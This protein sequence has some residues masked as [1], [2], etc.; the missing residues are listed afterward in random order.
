MDAAYQKVQDQASQWETAAGAS[1]GSATDKVTSI[2]PAANV[3]SL[4]D[5]IAD[6]LMDGLP[7]KAHALY[8]PSHHHFQSGGKLLRGILALASGLSHGVPQKT[9]LHWALAIEYMHNA[10]LVHDDLCDDDISRRN[11]PSIWVAFN[12]PMAICLGDWMIG[13][14]FAHAAAAQEYA[15]DSHVSG[16]LATTLSTL[17]TGQAKEFLPNQQLDIAAY[18]D[19]VAGKTTPLFVAAMEGI[20]RLAGQNDTSQI[21]A[22]QALFADIGIAY[23][24]AN[25][26]Q[27]HNQLLADKTD[28]D[29]LRDAPNAV[30]MCYRAGL[31]AAQQTAFDTWRAAPDPKA[32]ADSMANW[33][34]DIT[35]STAMAD[36]EALMH[37]HLASVKE[38]CAALPA[39]VEQLILPILKHVAGHHV[40]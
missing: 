13:Q 21:A 7:P 34:G 1:S 23:Q 10:S 35:A 15:P 36:A 20:L 33:L 2:K 27:D 11:R 32:D 26:M 12:R 25:D 30:Y 29:L 28:G 16:L 6:A 5:L 40:S 24:I 9:A 17:S 4:R 37:K 19:I 18:S 8:A 14:S 22:C 38:H 31:A 39:E 3:A